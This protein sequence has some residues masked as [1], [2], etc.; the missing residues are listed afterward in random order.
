MPNAEPVDNAFT[1][2]TRPDAVVRTVF[3]IWDALDEAGIG[4]PFPQRDVPIRELAASA[5]A[6]FPSPTA[7]RPGRAA[8]DKGHPV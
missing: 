6:P 1:N 3:A 8:V 2:R 4:N 5:A 7:T